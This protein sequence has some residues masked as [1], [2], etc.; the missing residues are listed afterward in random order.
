MFNVCEVLK[1]KS[2]TTYDNISQSDE[3]ICYFL[4]I[5]NKHVPVCKVMFLNT[6]GI[7]TGILGIGL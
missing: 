3:T 7:K 1:P 2:R 4:K 6:L 5:E